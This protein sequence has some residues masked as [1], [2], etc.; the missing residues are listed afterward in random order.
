[1]AVVDMTLDDAAF[2]AQS[3]GIVTELLLLLEG[4]GTTV[5]G[6]LTCHLLILSSGRG[7][8]LGLG[9]SR[10]AASGLRRSFALWLLE[11]SKQTSGRACSTAHFDPEGDHSDASLV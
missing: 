11:A 3:Y 7:Q 4:V 1:M 6:A 2:L 5:R 10:M 9:E 8:S